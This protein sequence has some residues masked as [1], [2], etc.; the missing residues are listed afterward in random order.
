MNEAT[1]PSQEEHCCPFPL[2]SPYDAESVRRSM[3][4]RRAINEER[5]RDIQRMEADVRRQAIARRKQYLASGMC[6]HGAYLS[7]C[8]QCS[9]LA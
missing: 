1:K 4:I 7:L 8:P 9:D 6:E 2:L 5:E 3:E